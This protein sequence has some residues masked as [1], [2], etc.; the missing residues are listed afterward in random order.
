MNGL[1]Y[2]WKF[3]YKKTNFCLEIVAQL[4]HLHGYL[5]FSCCN[6]VTV[7]GCLII[8]A[9]AVPIFTLHTIIDLTSHYLT[10]SSTE[11][12]LVV[13]IA[14]GCQYHSAVWVRSLQPLYL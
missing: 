12:C 14:G 1:P 10:A 9:D 6:K 5:L 4:C 13:Y 3:I 2:V 11:H 8:P 7:W